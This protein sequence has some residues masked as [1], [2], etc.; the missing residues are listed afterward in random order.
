MR[1]VSNG[2]S[3]S[4]L[5]NLTQKVAFG[6]REGCLGVDSGCKWIGAEGEKEGNEVGVESY[7]LG[8]L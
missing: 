4:E 8:H 2:G 7:E 5:S 1:S 3:H 6:E